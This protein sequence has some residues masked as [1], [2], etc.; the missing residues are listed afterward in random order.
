MAS[1]VLERVLNVIVLG[2]GYPD[3]RTQDLFLMSSF[4]NVTILIVSYLFV[5]YWVGPAFMSRFS[6]PLDTYSYLVWHNLFLVI[7][8]ALFGL[9]LLAC[10]VYSNQNL[11]CEPVRQGD[12]AS[13]LIAYLMYALLL[14]KIFELGDA[15]ALVC[16]KLDPPFI[17]IFH[18]VT[19]VAV[20]WVGVKYGPGG[21]ATFPTLLNS[22][23]HV[24]IYLHFK[25]GRRH[26]SQQ[27]SR[28]IFILIYFVQFIVVTFL[29]GSAMYYKCGYPDWVAAVSILYNI[30]LMLVYVR[31]VW[32]LWC[33]VR[34][35]EYPSSS[36]SSSSESEDE[37]VLEHGKAST[38]TNKSTPHNN[39]KK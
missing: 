33:T 36:S 23:I 27:Q 7:A 16:K 20:V 10:L 5:I 28:K 3:A 21:S 37:I 13:D 19:I 2:P 30:T 29:S 26:L 24:L 9:S 39:K 32:S 14:L 17:L 6:E 22:L 25:Y 31:S 35:V 12:V 38:T 1:V 18:H 34:P 8:N 11:L 15:F 4:W